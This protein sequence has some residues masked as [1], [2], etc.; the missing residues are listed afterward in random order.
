LDVRANEVLGVLFE[1]VVDLVEQ[2]VGLFGELLTTLLASGSTAGG[3]VVVAA[4][5]TSC[6]SSADSQGPP[7]LPHYRSTAGMPVVRW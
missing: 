5:T 4:A 1:H 2:I 3:I 6:L 7:V